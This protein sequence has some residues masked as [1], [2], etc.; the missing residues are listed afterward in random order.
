M[1]PQTLDPLHAD[2]AWSFKMT[3]ILEKQT[4]NSVLS[5]F[6]QSFELFSLHCNIFKGY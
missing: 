6:F 5:V 4:I 2:V 1:I 3:V